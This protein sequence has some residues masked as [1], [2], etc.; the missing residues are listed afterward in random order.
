MENIIYLNID[1]RYTFGKV[2]RVSN[3]MQEMF[4]IIFKDGY[5]NIFFTDVESGEWIEEDLGF[6]ELAKVVGS[7]I[8]RFLKAPFHVPKIL[9]WYKKIEKGKILNFG[10]FSF[11]SGDQKIYEIYDHNRKYRY[12]LVD[13]QNNEWQLLSGAESDDCDEIDPLFI[14]KVINIL[15]L[16]SR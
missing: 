8:R 9:S 4:R 6:T 1:G 12:T 14:D 10:F 7:Q 5:E 16:Y 13:M 3:K 11:K 2:S 15:P